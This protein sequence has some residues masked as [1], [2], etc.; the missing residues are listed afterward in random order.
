MKSISKDL[1]YSGIYCIINIYNGKRYIGSSKNI[2]KRLWG[3]RAELR[4]NKHDNQYLQNAWNKYGEDKFDFYVIEQCPE[5][6]LLEREQ[7]YIDT[8]KPEYNLNPITT[9]PPM[10][11]QSRRKLSETRKHKMSTGEIPL[12]HNKHIFQYDFDGNFIAE[13]VSIRRAAFANN[14]HPSQIHHCLNGTYKQGGGYQWSYIKVPKLPRYIKNTMKP[15]RK[16]VIVYNTEKM[17][18][19]NSAKE[20]A[21][22]FG[23]RVEV[24]RESIL[25]NRHFMRKYKIEYSV[26]CN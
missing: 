26:P 23:K 3:H 9:R 16:G 8:I 19:F 7:F 1:S 15:S 11:E 18:K 17:Y 21:E 22:F 20:C 24:I 13:Y 14:I 6:I 10:T 2:R 4:H 25:N 5:N 12:T